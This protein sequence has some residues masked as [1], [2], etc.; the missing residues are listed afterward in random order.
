[1]KKIALLLGFKSNKHAISN[2]YLI[3]EFLLV[4]VLI[5]LSIII[6]LT[7]SAQSG[8]DGS[9]SYTTAAT[10]ILNRYSALASSASSGSYI[11]SVSAIADLSGSTS[12]SNSVNPYTTAALSP[13]DLVFIIQMQGA[14]IDYTNTSTYGD[15]SAYNGVGDYEF[16]TVYSVSGNNIYFCDPLVNNYYVGGRKRAQV[17]RV[18][19]LTTLSQSGGSAN[20]RIITAK[21]WDGIVGGVCVLETSGNISFANGA[22]INAN[23]AGFL[24]GTKYNS[25]VNFGSTIY[26]STLTNEGGE[27]GESI[28]GS[29]SDYDTYLS[30]KRGRGAPANGG[31]G[32]NNHNAGGGGGSNAGSL[33]GWNGTGVKAAGYNNAWNL[34]GAGFAGNVSPGGGRGGYTYGANNGNAL[35]QGPGNAVWGGDNRRNVGGFGGRPLDYNTNTRVFMGGGGGA[36]DMN[37]GNGAN[38]GNGGGIVFIV[39]NGTISGSGSITALGQNG[40]NTINTGED[41]PGGGGGGGAIV[42]LSN[43]TITGITMSANGGTGGTQN[44]SGMGAESE[45]PGGGG[46]GGYIYTTN[47]S[48]TRTINGGNN[49][50]T[51]STGVTE[52]PPNGATIGG[53]GTV[54]N[55]AS[56]IN[57]LGSCFN[58]Y[59]NI[60][61]NNCGEG[62]VKLNTTLVKNGDFSLAITSPAPGNTFTGSN[63]ST[64]GTNYYFSGGSFQAQA[65]NS[66]GSSGHRFY[67]RTGNYTNGSINQ[68]PFPGDPAFNVPATNTWIHH[69]GNN[70][71]GERVLW[72]QNITGLING[73]NYTFYFYVSNV[74]NSDDRDDSNDPIINLRT[75]GTAGLPDGTLQLGPTTIYESAT[76]NSQSLDGWVRFSYS[77]TA[78]G[79][80]QRLKITDSRIGTARDEIG[81]TAIGMTMCETICEAPQTGSISGANTIIN[82][83]YPATASVT[84]GATRI[85]VGAK[86]TEGAGDDIQAGDLLMVIQMQGAAINSSNN[87]NY[88]ANNGTGRGYTSTVAG[89]YEYVYAASSVVGGKV[90]LTTPLKN[91][92]TNADATG[93]AGQYRF[94]VV[95]IPQ[96][97]SLYIAASAS[98]T[99]AE[100]NGSSGGIIAANVSGTMTL[101]GGVAIDASA[102]GFRGG[103]G[104]LLIDELDASMLNTDFRTSSSKDANGSKGEGI[105][106][107]PKYTRSI[108]DVLVDNGAEGYPNG[109]NA[110]G[111]P[112]NAGGGGTDGNPYNNDQ[113]TG[114]GGG[115]NGGIGGLGGRAWATPSQYGGYG[116]AIFN[117]RSAT[118]LVLGGGGGA[119]TTNNGT[120][121][122]LGG[123]GAYENGFY[124]SG[125]SGGGMIFLQVGGVSGTGTINA[126]GANGLGVEKDGGG[127]GGAGG[128]VYLYATNTTGMSN[129]TI[130]AKGGNGGN[131]WMSE[132]DNG[133][134]NDGSPEH[135]PG[136]G[137]GGGVIY[138]NAAVNA[139]S[140]VA[141]GIAGVTTDANYN[142]GAAN[143][144]VGYKGISSTNPMERVVKVFCDIDDDDDGI[145]DVIENSFGGEDAFLDFDG[146]SIPNVYDEIPGIDVT[147]WIDTNGDGI[148]D[149]F[150]QDLDGIIN[151]LDLDSDN[152]GVADVVESYGVDANGDGI[153]DN[154]VDANADGLSDNA[155]N[156]NSVNGIGSP[157]LD[158]D[159]IPNY[160][161]LDSDNDGIPDIIEVGGTDANNDGKVDSFSDN[162]YNGF[163]NNYEGVSNA[164]L[165][166]G[167]DNNNDGI[168]DSWN[169]KNQDL[170]GRPNPYDLDSDGDGITDAEESGLI[171]RTG[172]NGTV[173]ATAGIIL[174]PKTNGW[175]STVQGLASLNLTNTDSR[176]QANYL[177][178]DS[179]DDGISDNV[180]AQSTSGYEIPSDTDDDG[181]G[182]AD[183]YELPA[184]IGAFGGNG[185]T[186]FDKDGDGTP[187]YKDTDTDNDGVQDYIEGSGSSMYGVSYGSLNFTDTDGDGLVDQWDNNNI[188]SLTVGNY[189]KN[190]T[191]SEMGTGGD[192]NGPTPTGSTA[193]LP[194]HTWGPSADRDWRNNQILPLNIIAFTVN[195]NAPNATIQWKVQNELQTNYYDVEFSLNGT[196]FNKIF[197]VSAKNTGSAEYQQLHN[198]INYTQ[199][200][201]YYRIKQVDK[202][203]KIF[204]T[205]IA[206]IRLNRNHEIKVS[207]NPFKNYFNVHYTSNTN[208]VVTMNI[209]SL[210]G[211]LISTKQVE[212]LRGNNTILFS[213]LNY[214][215]N[216]MYILQV[217][218]NHQ[219]NT[220]KI[221]KE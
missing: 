200:V 187:D 156:T 82:T 67:I 91:A 211:K 161:D 171:G 217:H 180:E 145:A 146:D 44:I 90:Y 139:A 157:D 144:N 37:D 28:A 192:R 53:S 56:F 55:T 131:A 2:D 12:F 130:N 32:G 93:S 114:G 108:A 133:T 202:D 49:G 33:T 176:G 111:A 109:S 16:K 46:G 151:E 31:G 197:T 5:I 95:R 47:T 78:S 213:E 201:F 34:E 196:T 212:V 112:G 158:D 165:K 174:G 50:T 59:S 104:R 218:S 159:G 22:T 138:S 105:A 123:G 179:D 164:L 45:G 36:G 103:G 119:G 141:G 134:A 195:Y 57:I 29:Q 106:G 76:T 20:T 92:Y 63:N 135:G 24:G 84:G 15:I 101:N 62:Y 143:G 18:P 51:N 1:M 116:G 113:N 183:A 181:D 117:E 52:F 89:T 163:H 170:T 185:L 71:G 207:P 214:L 94:Q 73:K 150:D 142:Y 64:A 203:G 79:T 205:E 99:N 25:A 136:G 155:A 8:K 206:S 152:D 199:D 88:G 11:V 70:L 75:G 148:N 54:L 115:G 193:T 30:G 40:A 149:N 160:L 129:I 35:T 100:W 128:S 167:S 102:L 166:S 219:I 85:Q 27:K 66:A 221:L 137:G 209:I 83:Y 125:G 58:G 17:I 14:D 220:F 98:I 186:P 48:I 97:T 26:R 127:G 39:T 118:R 4:I 184:Q 43:S 13:G 126:N 190:V 96:Y 122:G 87:N 61:N 168:A 19:R 178:I 188:T 3:T 210:D 68:D 7:T 175:A 120:A 10:R 41:G 60:G 191:N 80:T 6:P 153:I 38:G 124:S 216:G 169:T 107:T 194:Q 74:Y 204:Y 182:L 23:Y 132:P 173:A 215:Q 177:D 21:P 69:N 208:Q 65:D 172:S 121:E 72:D 86:R 154:F 42:V 110:Q 189:Y 162:D 140:S 147:D 77:F 81:L 198:L 9:V